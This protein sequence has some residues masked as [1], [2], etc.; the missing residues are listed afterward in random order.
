MNNQN[1]SDFYDTKDELTKAANSMYATDDD[2]LKA[3]YMNSI[4]SEM[5]KL[6]GE[7]RELQ[8]SD[9]PDAEKYEAVREVQRQIDELAKSG[10]D[11]YN[12]VLISGGYATVGDRHYRKKDGEWSK[13]TD[14]QLEK[15]EEVTSG[16]GISPAD[17]WSN[18]E[19]YDFAYEKPEKYAVAKAVG[20]YDSY[21]TYSDEL[22]D[23]KAD[24][25]ENGDS[26]RNSRKEKVIDWVNNLDADY[27]TRIILFKNEYNADDTYNYDIIEYLNSRDD[28]S[29]DD[30]VAILKELG[31]DVDANGNI[32][33]D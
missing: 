7:K 5:G 29:Y 8:N 9:M 2:V 14:D 21:Q 18:K 26:I 13:L 4:N 16:L 31:F 32:S 19:E 28:I 22:Y 20:G 10:L 12:E 30:M 11:T 27:G 17:Y 15:Q 24:K 25:D 33:W 23:I 3:K 1:V 6:Y